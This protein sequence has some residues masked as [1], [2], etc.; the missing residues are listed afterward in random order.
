MLLRL[1]ELRE[2]IK[3]VG[4]YDHRHDDD[5]DILLQASALIKTVRGQTSPRWEP[6]MLI[7]L[8]Q[9]PAMKCSVK[10]VVLG[11]LSPMAAITPDAVNKIASGCKVFAGKTAP[12][13]RPWCSPVGF[14]VQILS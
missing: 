1:R 9:S 7:E 8:L 2:S 6:S 4:A 3:G 14:L 11:P 5:D 12:P 13:V 10:D